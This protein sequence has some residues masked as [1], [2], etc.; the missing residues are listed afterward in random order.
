MFGILAWQAYGVPIH[1]ETAICRCWTI[2]TI[3][4]LILQGERNRSTWAEV[5]KHF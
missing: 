2:E 3:S 5:V 4:C 1:A